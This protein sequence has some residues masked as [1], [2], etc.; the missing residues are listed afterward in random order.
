VTIAVGVDGDSGRKVLGTIG[1]AGAETFWTGFLRNVA[2]RGL[3]GVKLIISDAHEGIRRWRRCSARSRNAAKRRED[4]FQSQLDLDPERHVFI[5]ESWRRQTM[6]TPSTDG[7]L[8]REGKRMRTFQ[9]HFA[10]LRIQYGT[11][12]L[13]ELPGKMERLKVSRAVVITGRSLGRNPLGLPRLQSLLQD[14]VVAVF[15]RVE[16]HS[17][18]PSVEH[19]AEILRASGADVIIALGGGSAVVTARAAAI[20]YGEARPIEELHTRFE[21][22]K[23]PFSPKL[24]APKLPIFAIPTTAT[25][26]CAKAGTAILDPVT[27]R[28]LTLFDP[29]TRARELLI[30]PEL[31]AATPRAL[32]MDAGLHS[33]SMAVQ[34]LESPRREPFAD[35]ALIHALRLLRD[36]LPLL[37]RGGD[38]PEVRGNLV[39]AAILAGEG[40]DHTGGGSLVSVIGHCLGARTNVGNGLINALLL[41]HTIRFNAPETGDRL[42]VLGEL[43]GARSSSAADVAD[44]CAR[45]FEV[46]GV[47]PRLSDA[48]IG[49]E[50]FESVAEDARSDWF[51]Y[52]NP[53]KILSGGEI[54]SLLQDASGPTAAAASRAEPSPLSRSF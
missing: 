37:G 1:P 40:T 13:A 5:N 9:H 17:P 32:M 53:R 21:P 42:A 14:Q 48:G 39:L 7:L 45:Y 52:Q 18:L 19:A 30:D 6:R 54:V 50:L 3:R 2:R 35:A 43:L 4:W 22:G 27:R 49:E 29:K 11:S 46:L 33:F 34:G 10:P 41:P 25:T 15:D 51:L 24:L 28:R 8:N 23:A 12:C 20:L 36:N 44:A 38:G 47:P 16:A 26:A 31:A